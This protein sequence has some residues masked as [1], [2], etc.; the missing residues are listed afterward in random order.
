MNSVHAVLGIG[1]KEAAPIA[2]DRVVEG[3]PHTIACLDYQRDGKVFAGEW[4]ATAGAWRV[5]YDEWEFCHML[6]GECELEAE[7]GDKR[8]FQIGDSFVIEPGFI[9]VWRVLK[10]MK[11][12]FV[13]RYD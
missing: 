13:V 10:P 3:S 8:R 9:G 6:E 2:A 4:S 7:D 1:P 12:R 11:K 5:R